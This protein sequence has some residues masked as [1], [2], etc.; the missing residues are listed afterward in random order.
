MPLNSYFI[1]MHK[2]GK[3]NSLLN[4]KVKAKE[5]VQIFKSNE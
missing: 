2:F 5:E 3:G 1:I 4:A